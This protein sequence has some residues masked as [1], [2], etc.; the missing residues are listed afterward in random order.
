MRW[1]NMLFHWIK[2]YYQ[3]NDFAVSQKGRREAFGKV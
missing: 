2:I 3:G 1:E